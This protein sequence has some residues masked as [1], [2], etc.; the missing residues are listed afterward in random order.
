M[1]FK[2]AVEARPNVPTVAKRARFF[3][4]RPNNIMRSMFQRDVLGFKIM[5]FALL[6]ALLNACTDGAVELPG[7]LPNAKLAQMINASLDEQIKRMDPGWSRGLLPQAAAN[8]RLWL[9]DINEVVARCRHG[10][11]NNSKFN[12][13]EYDISLRTGEVIKDVYT[14]QRCTY[15]I[16][17]PLV[18]RVRF[19]GGRVAEALTDGRERHSPVASSK[20]DIDQLSKAVIRADWSRRNALY[21]VPG[22]T[23]SEISKEWQ[24]GKP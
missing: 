11:R 8:A 17:L 5:A 4:N 24:T 22:K 2:P 19:L 20:G 14:G 21:F 18:M 9:Q 13:L 16:G 3:S 12:L 15:E 7:S 23:A 10:P 1:P 6:T